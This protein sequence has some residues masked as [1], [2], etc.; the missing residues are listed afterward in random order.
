MFYRQKMQDKRISN[1]FIQKNNR[2]NVYQLLRRHSGLTRQDVVRRLGLS[3]PTVVNNINDLQREGLIREEG[4][5]GNT[6][7][8]SAKTYT[9]DKNA[10]IAFGLD[11]TRD[12]VIAV[13]VNLSG[14]VNFRKQVWIKYDRA[15]AYYRA[16]GNVVKT[17]AAAVGCHKDRILGVGIG[18]P[19]LVTE[20][21]QTVFYGEILKFTGATCAEFSKY[22]PYKTAIFND[23]SAAGFGEFWIREEPGS[24]FY[25]SL[26]NNIGGA[27]IIENRILG[28]V[29]FHSGEIGHLTLHPNGRICY[30]GQKGCVDPYLAATVLA[31]ACNGDLAA[32]FK[33]LETKDKKTCALW[34]AYLNDLALAVSNVQRLFDC[35]VIL[36][37][38]IAE[39]IDPYLPELKNRAAKRNSFDHNADYIDICRYRTW[40]IAAGAALNFVSGF[41]G[42]I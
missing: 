1:R 5:V 12:Y 24:A 20:D 39:Y 31:G 25:I 18:V 21:N 6:G 15:D 41:I 37:G 16:L 30:C 34:D 27:V 42:S 19:G 32:F 3:L 26:S 33:L 9:F 4:S 17:M 8:R 23:A 14:E 10:R 35:T 38:Y 11:I 22:I 28:G 36:G 13:A 29:H 40:S 2:T 7:G